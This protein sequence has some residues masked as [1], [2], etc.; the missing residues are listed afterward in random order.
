MMYK[1]MYHVFN[2]FFFP[3]KNKPGQKDMQRILDPLW[4]MQLQP[5]I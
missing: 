5:A 2:T 1:T 3:K 4:Y